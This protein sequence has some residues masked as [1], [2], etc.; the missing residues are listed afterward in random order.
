MPIYVGGKAYY[1][2]YLGGVELTASPPVAAPAPPPAPAGISI[3]LVTAN[4]GFNGPTRRGS[5]TPASY[6]PPGRAA[7]TFLH[8]RPVGAGVNFALAGTRVAADFPTRFTATFGDTTLTFTPRSGTTPR[9]ISGGTRLDYDPTTGA[10]GDVFGNG[11][12]IAVVL[13]YD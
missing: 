8:L 13:Y 2:A 3:A 5:V 11:R 9:S 6:T 4:G 10:V 12:S 1:R 7:V